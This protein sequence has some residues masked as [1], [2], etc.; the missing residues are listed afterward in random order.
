MKKFYFLT[1]L[2][3]LSVLVKAE[4]ITLDLSQPSN[5]EAFVFDENGMWT[6]TW[7]E[8]GYP[9][10]DTQIFSFSHLPS[11][12]SWGKTS[13]EGFTVSKATA[14]GEGTG[15][16]SNL[17]KGGIKGEGTPYIWAYFSE[18]WSYYSA[19]NDDMM[20]SNH[21]IF[22]DGQEYY[23]R[24]VYLNI[25]LV[26]YN[27]VM[28]GSAFARSFEK[29]DKYEVW[30][31]GLD[32]DYEETEEKV[33]YRLADFTSENES[34]WFVNTDWAFVDLSSLGKVS[35]LS[36]KVVSTDQ[37]CD[38]GYCYTNTATYFALDG[39]TVSTT[40]NVATF[41]NEAGGI[42]LTAE[43]SNWFG[44]DAPA[45]GWSNWK[46]DEFNF[47]SYNSVSEYGD[48]HS[49][50]VVT[51]ETSTDFDDYN[52]DAWRSASGGAFEGDNFAVWNHNYYG[53][54]QITFDA[55]V[56]PGFYINNTAYAV[57]SMCESDDFAEDP[58]DSDSWF[59]LTITGHKDGAEVGAVEFYLAKDGKYVSQWT[60]VDLSSLGVIDAVTF[61]MWSTDVSE[62]Y[63]TEYMNTPEYFAMD[64]FGASKPADY[65]AP[66][67]T[68]FPSHTTAIDNTENAVS[69]S[70]VLRNGQIYIL[71]NGEMY[72]IN[73]AVVR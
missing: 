15:Y 64:N 4:V 27:D 47:Q 50:F 51:N 53:D 6:E 43:E 58:F 57:H 12:N 30:I 11:G 68:P 22:N 23:P 33:A 44:A 32:E 24:Y 70:K 60:Y 59:R 13:W 7:N 8:S 35:G 62:Y 39:L 19:D 52:T 71:R 37:G 18:Y 67:M 41:E 25:S 45:T 10:F 28:D 55:Q 69:A 20:S 46:S 61:S 48:Y 14:D 49:A 16:Y 56:I 17:A 63:G 9:Y 3:A 36:F 72:N 66:E 38:Y 54:D 34:E 5:P 40:P 42:N 26:G 65:V 29:G 2:L 31:Y 73:G 1:A 21:I